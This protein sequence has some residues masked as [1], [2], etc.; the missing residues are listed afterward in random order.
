MYLISPPDRRRKKTIVVKKELVTIEENGMEVSKAGQFQI[1]PER[2]A[3]VAT[4]IQEY[5][6]KY[7]L[8]TPIQGK[9]YAQV[10][11]WQYAGLLMGLFPLVT[12]VENLSTED[13][14]KYRARVEVVTQDGKVVGRGEA[15]CSNQ[16]QKKKHFDEYAIC[17]MA[18][19]RAT[20]KAFR[21]LMGWMFK[22]A[23]METTPAEEME[24]HD[25]RTPS[26]G[27][28]ADAV[29]KEFQKFAMRALDACQSAS[30][31]EVLVKLA[32]TL[33]ESDAKFI[34]KAR[35]RYKE[36]GNVGG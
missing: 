16:E 10:E 5:A 15:V 28:T 8:T 20:G 33:K 22:L 26:I 2:A 11:A 14:F 32:P 12:D 1:T 34:D 18:Q 27:P 7:K 17:S 29:K 13:Y 6:T 21:L 30:E 23:G 24:G 31:I 35:A 9:E 4:T 25:P 36:L 19:T 3:S